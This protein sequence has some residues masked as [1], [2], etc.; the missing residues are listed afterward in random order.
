MEDAGCPWI[1]AM[2]E[3]TYIEEMRVLTMEL[4]SDNSEDERDAS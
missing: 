2:D 4:W 3:V 1:Q